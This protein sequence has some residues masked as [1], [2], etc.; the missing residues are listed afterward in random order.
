MDLFRLAG[1][2]NP[3]CPEKRNRFTETVIVFSSKQRNRSKQLFNLTAKHN[4]QFGLAQLLQI[5]KT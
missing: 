3:F 4:K 1:T 2:P 5:I